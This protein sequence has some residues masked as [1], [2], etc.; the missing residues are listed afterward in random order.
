MR[1]ILELLRLFAA[2]AALLFVALA[3]IYVGL[4][5]WAL[6]ARELGAFGA[7]GA[8]GALTGSIGIRMLEELRGG[9]R[10]RRPCLGGSPDREISALPRATIAS[11]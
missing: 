8:L 11:R 6:W 3:M 9:R 10:R 4:A 5:V 2:A 1:W 7:M